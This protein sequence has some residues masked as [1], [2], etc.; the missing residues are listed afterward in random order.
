MK[1][2]FTLIIHQQT[3]EKFQFVKKETQSLFTIF[4][5]IIKSKFQ[6]CQIQSKIDNN[7]FFLMLTTTQRIFFHNNG[8]LILENIIPHRYLLALQNEANQCVEMICERQQELV[9]NYGC[10]VGSF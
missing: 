8:Y 3:F 1:E 5:S 7:K 2:F 6:I 9:E 4:F 10:I